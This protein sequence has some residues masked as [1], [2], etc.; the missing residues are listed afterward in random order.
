[1]VSLSFKLMAFSILLNLSVGFFISIGTGGGVLDNGWG[2]GS[3]QYNPNFEQPLNDEFAKELASPPVEGSTSFGEK[4]LD[5][6]SIGLYTKVKNFL[7]STIFALPD[8]FSNAGL[9][10][11]PIRVIMNGFLL[12]LYSV[13]MFELFTG[14]RLWG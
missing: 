14:K 5:F 3:M 1:M 4:I 11:K 9:I 10:T 12:L 8:F 13:G 6:F 2:A 7:N